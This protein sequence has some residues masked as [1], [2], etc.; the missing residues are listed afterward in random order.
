MVGVLLTLALPVP[1]LFNRALLVVVVHLVLL[2]PEVPMEIPVALESLA[3]WDP[4]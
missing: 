3:S 4:E 1:L 2:V